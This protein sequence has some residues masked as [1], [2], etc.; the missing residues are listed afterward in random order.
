MLLSRLLIL[1]VFLT[2]IYA[3]TTAGTVVNGKTGEPLKGALVTVQCFTR[4]GEP[5]ALTALTDIAGAFRFAAQTTEGCA[6]RAEKP[7]FQL[8]TA[9][10]GDNLRIALAPFGVITGRVTGRD[11]QPVDRAIVLVI[12]LRIQDGD[13]QPLISRTLTTDDRGVF[14]AWNLTPGKYY[15]KVSGRTGGTNVSVAESLPLYVEEETVVPTYFGGPT[16][17]SAT[18]LKLDV[19]DEGKADI[20]VEWRTGFRIAGRLEGFLPRQ[21][22]KFE[23]AAGEE[24]PA[25]ARGSVSGDGVSFKVYDVVPGSYLLRATQGDTIAEQEV[26]VKDNHLRGVTLAAAAPVEVEVVGQLV[27]ARETGLS[28]I[29]VPGC[30]VSL[31]PIGRFSGS[32]PS[33]SGRPS[34]RSKIAGVR[35]GRYR[36]IF[37]C[38]NGYV[39][40]AVAGLQDLLADPVL[41]ITSGAAPPAIEMVSSGK[42]G[43]ISVTVDA[44]GPGERVG[45]LLIPQMGASAGPQGYT[46]PGESFFSR[47]LRGRIWRTRCRISMRSSIAIPRSRR[48]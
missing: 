40:S 36:V 48:P 20:Q 8:A 19:G 15:V 23:L 45:V 39:R 22:V 10:R 28:R 18:P 43:T 44:V 3:Q 5:K 30:A 14:R 12:S 34:A 17:A 4:Q 11:R 29:G 6:V 13:R 25:I 9:E 2:A 1:A 41:T 35:P 21:N 46:A 26:V 38:V 24:P 37:N 16:L 47:S 7:G 33:L 42:S 27:D 32:A 31:R